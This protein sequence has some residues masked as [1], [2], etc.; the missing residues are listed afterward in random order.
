M[1]CELAAAKRL[2]S[3]GTALKYTVSP[4]HSVISSNKGIIL[5]PSRAIISSTK[6]IVQI[7]Y[8]Y[9]SLLLLFDPLPAFPPPRP[10]PPNCSASRLNSGLLAISDMLGIYWI[11]IS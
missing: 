3:V 5:S 8:E 11:Q 9:M 4:H 7:V 10:A 6:S 1:G 2:G